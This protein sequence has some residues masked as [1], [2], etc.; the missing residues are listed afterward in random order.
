MDENR[1]AKLMEDLALAL[2]YLS[3]WKE[4]GFDTEVHRAWKGYDFALLDRLKEEG[5]IDFS[6]TAKS[7]YLSVEGVKRAE[8]LVE[9]FG[10]NSSIAG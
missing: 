5:M 3:A 9:K 2:I 10:S 1:K 8:Q 7:L 4:K 6:Y